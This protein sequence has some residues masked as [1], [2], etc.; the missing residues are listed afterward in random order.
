M[1]LTQIATLTE[2]LPFDPALHDTA[3]TAKATRTQN[4][5]NSA[6]RD[7]L[8]VQIQGYRSGA[9]TYAG[10]TWTTGRIGNTAIL[11]F[12][13]IDASETMAEALTTMARTGVTRQAKRGVFGIDLNHFT[14]TH[15]YLVL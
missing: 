15:P 13:Y 2:V 6:V 9:F 5:L 8:R 3:P 4:G 14:Y 1:A 10:V 11:S 7:K 12:R